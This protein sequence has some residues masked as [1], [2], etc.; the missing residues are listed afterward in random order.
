MFKKS[1]IAT[2]LIV[3]SILTLSTL[4][5]FA[6]ADTYLIN[7][8]NTNKNAL[9]SYV[10]K[11]S[12]NDFKEKTIDTKKV[13]DLQ[14]YQEDKVFK[15]PKEKKP[16]TEKTLKSQNLISNSKIND[17][18]VFNTINMQNNSNDRTKA[19]LKYNGQT[20]NVWVADEYISDEQ[21]Q[22][23]GEEFD[24]NIDPLVRDKFG[25]PSDVDRDGKVNILI[26]DIKDDFED[27]GSYT[28]GYFH[29]RDLYDVPYS[30]KAEVF[31]M[32]TY[33]SMGTD[34]NNL[35]EKKVYSTLAHEYQHMVNANQKLL[36]EKKRD[37]MD[38]WLDEAF[39]M[40]SEHMYL[41]KTLD[42]RIDYYNNSKSIA[43][44]HSLIKWN[45]R[46]DVLSNYSLSYLFSQ[47]LKAQSDNGDKIFKEILQD[48]S[49][50]NKALEK[51]I[52]K[53]VDANMSL[54]EFMTNFRIA[55]EKK[56][57]AGLHGFNGEPGFNAINPKPVYQLP[58][59]L[60]P[61]GSVLFET[62]ENFEIPKDK[63]ESITYKKIE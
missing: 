14:S 61:Q 22:N 12:E 38:V 8:E 31:Y 53:H 40:A 6:E 39:A 32:D 56:E 37:G 60:A 10:G 26:Y 46:G 35:N 5:S 7:N 18:R 57:D 47:Y 49:S 41:G 36:K 63:D 20:T 50:T 52:H 19:K 55:L 59:T 23:I 27:T 42:H 58:Q 51:A 62:S 30:N 34:R 29:P 1:K 3:S 15:A 25:S 44:G 16:I 21:A 11:S 2:T 43:N 4:T 33:P 13:K 9:E 45:H 28:G 24:K 54:G 17:V 48:H